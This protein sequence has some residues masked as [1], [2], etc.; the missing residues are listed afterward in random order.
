VNQWIL[1]LGGMALA[2]NMAVAAADP[3]T[4][5]QALEL[6]DRNSSGLRAA[7]LQSRAAK[8]AI[9]GAGLLANPQVE[10]EAENIDAEDGSFDDAEYTIGISRWIS[11]GKKRKAQ[12]A[13]SEHAATVALKA[14][15]AER[16]ALF[17]AVRL[18]FFD[19]QAQQEAAT[20]QVDQQ[21]LGRAFI[22]VAKRRHSAG[23]GSRLEVVQ[24]ELAL[25]EIILSQACCLGELLAAKEKLAALIGVPGDAVQEVSG[26]FYEP[27]SIEGLVLDEAHPRLLHVD[28]QIE[29]ALARAEEARTQDA[30]DWKLRGGL[31]HDSGADANSVIVAISAPLTVSRKGR[32][33]GVAI[34]VEVDALRARRDQVLRQL[35]AELASET[36][37]Y[38]GVLKEV[39]VISENLLPKAKEAYELSLAGYEA[40]RFS[41]YE[42]IAAQQHLADIRLRYLDALKEAHF[43][44]SRISDLAGE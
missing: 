21:E 35:Q 27:T 38:G 10:I 34:L 3:L 39:E 5:E 20:V 23:A 13:A 19:V 2:A 1:L 9:P 12:R 37:L 15:A 28:A 6:A 32:I 26:P 7:R 43:V 36:A 22:E 29:E 17:T 11:R 18:A 4:L 30:A 16:R 24:A 42:L 33:E 41:W 44:R 40:G 8:A 25:Q 31:K 14:E